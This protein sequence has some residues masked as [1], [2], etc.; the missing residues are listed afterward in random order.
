MKK[1]TVAFLLA[2]HC[3]TGVVGFAA[4]IYALLIL[5]APPAPSMAEV[6]AAASEATFTAQFRCD[7]KDSD[8]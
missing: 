3:A 4:G 1:R 7:L 8:A 2:T 6:R 5:I